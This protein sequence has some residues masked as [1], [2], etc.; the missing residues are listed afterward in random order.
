MYIYV[1]V[2]VYIVNLLFLWLY[3]KLLRGVYNGNIDRFI[4]AVVLVGIII[5]II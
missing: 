3:F 5:I 2:Y 1:Y 4:I